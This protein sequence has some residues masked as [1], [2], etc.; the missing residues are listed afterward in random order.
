[1]V[2]DMIRKSVERKA[3]V[4]VCRQIRNIDTFDINKSISQIDSLIVWEIDYL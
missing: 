3:R 2:K 1:M 4:L